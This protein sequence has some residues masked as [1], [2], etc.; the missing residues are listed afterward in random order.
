MS[1][2]GKSN[3]RCQLYLLRSLIIWLP[4][5]N[6]IKRQPKSSALAPKGLK[7]IHWETNHRDGNQRVEFQLAYKSKGCLPQVSKTGQAAPSQPPQV[8]DKN[9]ENENYK[10]P[11]V[12][13]ALLPGYL[14]NL[15]LTYNVIWINRKIFNCLA[16]T[17]CTFR[18]ASPH[19]RLSH[20][21]FPASLLSRDFS[22]FLWQSLL[23][24]LLP[25]SH[26]GPLI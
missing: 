11:F 16:K 26:L 7:C 19:G 14:L 4:Y 17:V 9:N 13:I 6:H 5:L 25:P 21:P 1:R 2:M 8:I 23:A 18:N 12:L 24:S 10:K 15:P 20:T 22:Y 3:F